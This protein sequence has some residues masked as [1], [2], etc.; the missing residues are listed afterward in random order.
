MEKRVTRS[1]IIVYTS[2]GFLFGCCFP[3][4]AY[5]LVSLLENIPFL[6]I[7]KL[8]ESNQLLYMIDTA[9]VFLG[10]F[11]LLG[12]LNQR[13]A[14]INNIR[15]EET[16]EKISIEEEE[17]TRAL[18]GMEEEAGIISQLLAG[19]KRTG[20]VLRSNE[21]VLHE[22]VSHIGEQEA[23][24][25]NLIEQLTASMQGMDIFFTRLSNQSKDDIHKVNQMKTISH[26]ALLTIGE[27]IDMNENSAMKLSSSQGDLQDLI[28][29]A[30]E[31]R[32]TISLIDQI[33]DQIKLL[34]LNASIES[35]RAGEA[36]AGF[37]VVAEEIKK[38]SEQTN[39]ATENIESN[40][41]RLLEKI[42]S[43]HKG[44]EAVVGWSVD[45]NMKNVSTK[46]ML[47]NMD[48]H[49]GDI[50]DSYQETGRGM[51]KL[52]KDLEILK[53]QLE[54]IDDNTNA[55]NDYID[56]GKMVLATNHD[57]MNH[58]QKLILQSGE[59]DRI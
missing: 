39:Y 19:I 2:I 14:L 51:L 54:E 6:N 47:A 29:T 30:S 13:K 20:G 26:D 8:H 35:A 11:A 44:I 7:I 31:T 9:P 43:I 42:T 59:S 15:L 50:M 25:E 58:L 1:T 56:K 38:L 53:C 46:E 21:E 55:L 12:G 40:I 28:T 18:K 52:E 34:A 17:K 16:M 49:T 22:V 33:S 5:F 57:E 36:G 41:S 27:Y 32:E 4:G 48:Q 23:E 45:V 3:L 37:A 10:A 24:L